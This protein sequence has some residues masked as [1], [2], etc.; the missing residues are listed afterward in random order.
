MLGEL[1]TGRFLLADRPWTDLYV[2]LCMHK[3]VAPPLDTLRAAVRQAHPQVADRVCA[4]VARALHQDPSSRARLVDLYEEAMRIL[5]DYH[6]LEASGTP[7]A[8]SRHTSLTNPGGAAAAGAA[9]GATPASMKKGASLQ[10]LGTKLLER[11]WKVRQAE[12]SLAPLPID[13]PYPILSQK[14]VSQ[15]HTI[16]APLTPPS[17]S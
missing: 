16:R 9:T 7:V 2:S 5:L 10:S 6:L 15:P 3:Y 4:M 8:Q 1:A 12:S 11:S 17:Y 14:R 13:G